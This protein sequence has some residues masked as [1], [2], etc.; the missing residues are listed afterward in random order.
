[1]ARVYVCPVEAELETAPAGAGEPEA[2][3]AERGVALMEEISVG[4]RGCAI[5]GPAREPL[6]SSGE[7]GVWGEAAAGLL[8]AADAARPGS[9]AEQVHVGTED[10]EV[11]AVRLGEVAMVAVTDRFTLASLVVSDMRAILRDLAAGEVVDRRAPERGVA[12][13]E[14]DPEAAAPPAD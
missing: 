5:L 8:D 1:M 13:D 4:L 2:A 6:A 12:P 3:E 9:H 7:A 11:F 10:G 14:V